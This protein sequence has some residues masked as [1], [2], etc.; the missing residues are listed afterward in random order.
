M[1][2]I[3][4]ILAIRPRDPGKLASPGAPFFRRDR[5]VFRQSCDNRFR[6]IEQR[7]FGIRF[8]VNVIQPVASVVFDAEIRR[9]QIKAEMMRLRH[10]EPK[11]DHLGPPRQ[12]FGRI[13]RRTNN[14]QMRASAHR[15]PDLICS[16]EKPE[17]FRMPEVGI[18][19]NADQPLQ[20]RS[21]RGTVGV[22]L[23]R[24]GFEDPSPAFQEARRGFGRAIGRGHDADFFAPFDSVRR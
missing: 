12:F 18:E 19:R 15:P 13:G 21:Q 5:E 3:I 20:L 23:V 14:R 22:L 11:F 6:N 8:V 16:Q 4:R 10:L 2:P 1:P 24:I 17:F 7:V 9:V